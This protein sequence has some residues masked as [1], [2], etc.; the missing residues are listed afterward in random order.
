MPVLKGD[1]SVREWI[2][3]CT[4]ITEKKQSDEL[5]WQQANFDSL[6]GLPNRDMFRDRLRQGLLNT[7]RAN[8][9]LA[10]LLVD[11][12][13]FKHV[14]DTLGHV[15]G[16]TLLQEAAR[17]IRACVRESDT[18]ARL[19]GDEFTVVLSELDDNSRSEDIAQKIINK[20]AEP[21]QLGNEIVYMSGSIG[22]TLYP[23]DAT[24]IDNLIR[25]ADQSMYV[26]KKKGRNRFSYF[27][28]ALQ[29]AAKARLRLVN[30]L[31]GALADNQFRV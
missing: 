16:D 5:I 3:T 7:D 8:L 6:T 31:R 13:Q 9:L 29:E 30:D 18:V 25:N 15:V 22:V 11:L 20:L 23:N 1:G 28:P 27:T 10:L 19:G 14:N 26:A 12:D 4:D 2:G 17:R 21:Y 24:D